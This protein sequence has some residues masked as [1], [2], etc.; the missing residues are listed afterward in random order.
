M[1]VTIKDIA[2]RVGVNPSTVSRVMNGTATI[3]EETKSK[4][5][6]AMKE[7][8]YH[9]NSQARNLVHGSTFTI[10]LVIDAG[11]GD[12]FL[13][14]FFIRSVCAIETVTQEK[15][16]NLL[17]TNNRLRESKNAIKNLILECKADGLIL[18]VSSITRELIELLLN[19]NFPFVVMGEPE[20]K[21]EGIF[22]I[23]TDNAQGSR[24]AVQHLKQAG[25]QNPVLFVENKGTVFERNRIQGF[26]QGLEE[27][28]IEWKKD[29][30][31]ESET[32]ADAI[33]DRVTKLLHVKP[34]PDSIICTNNE[35][36][37]HVMRELK[38]KGKRIPEDIGIITFDNYPLAE[39]LEPQLTVVDVDTYRLGEIAALALFD[40]I[41]EKSRGEGQIIIPT[42]LIKRASTQKEGGK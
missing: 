14:A 20:E 18:P 40:R 24:L 42:R 31:A 11:D 28:G 41:K 25:Y 4:I 34:E 38:K 15:G 17:I 10:G 13:N 7:M 30:I 5:Q 22:W 1:S 36:A 9:P 21:K 19:N 3:S 37:C 16:Y 26:K 33:A 2:K 23:D 39:Y 29:A 32:K 35:V 8:N 12:A 27:A 6:K